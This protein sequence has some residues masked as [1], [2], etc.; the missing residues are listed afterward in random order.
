M[1]EQ[2]HQR[3][4]LS[5]PQALQDRP[6]LQRGSCQIERGLA[7]DPVGC[8]AAPEAASSLTLTGGDRWTSMLR[9]L[10]PEA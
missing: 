7:I 2:R 6:E 4:P 1:I 10:L 9:N 8:V 5:L 3:G